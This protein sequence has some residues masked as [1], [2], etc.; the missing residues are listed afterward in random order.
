MPVASAQRM[1]H[2]READVQN[3]AS[4]GRHRAGTSDEIGLPLTLP[5]TFQDIIAQIKG[6][7]D[8]GSSRN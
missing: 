2:D 6:R 5:C 4:S 1:I 7:R 8:H 3:I